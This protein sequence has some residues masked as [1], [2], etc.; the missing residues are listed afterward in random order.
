MTFGHGV[1]MPLVA[2]GCAL[3]DAKAAAET[4]FD[5]V[6]TGVP[7]SHLTHIVVATPSA[8][9]STH[10]PGSQYLRFKRTS[11]T[12]HRLVAKTDA[13]IIMTA[14]I[15]VCNVRLSYK[16]SY[17]MVVFNLFGYSI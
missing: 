12:H 14:F 3:A 7:L 16:V 5:G 11:L 17:G 1:G 10:S 13:E 2:C 9:A 15:V 4:L 6:A 8:T